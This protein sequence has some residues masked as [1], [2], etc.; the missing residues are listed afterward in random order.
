[1]KL[2]VGLV[3]AAMLLPGAVEAKK[4]KAAKIDINKQ[5]ELIDNAIRAEIAACPEKSGGVYLV[6]PYIASPDSLPPVP[7]GFEPVYISHYGRHGSRWHT[8]GDI[9]EKILKEFAK[10]KEDGNLTSTGE[11]VMG[12]VQICEDNAKG[13]TGEL[14]HL[15]E[16]QHKSIATRMAKRFPTLFETGDTIVARSSTEPR[17]I[18]SML[19]FSEALKEY[20]P[21]MVVQR[22]ASPGDQ[23]FIRYDSK[24]AQSLYDDSKPW[25]AAYIHER[26]SLFES[27]ATASKLFVNPDK[28]NN[29]PWFMSMLHNIAFTSQNIDDLNVNILPYFDNEDLYNLWKAENHGYYL[30]HGNAPESEGEGPKSSISLLQDILDRSDES[31]AGKRTQVDLRFGHDTYLERLLSLMQLGDAKAV[32]HGIDESSRVWRNYHL[33]P[34]AANLQLIVFRNAAG[35]EIAT[36]RLNERPQSVGELTE[37]APGY[38][39]WTDLRN[40]WRSQVSEK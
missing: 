23:K 33:T 39:R 35:E 6:Y 34:M 25:R 8:W 16:L 32:V 38:Y 29:L 7:A 18:I 26:D 2:A 12:L 5:N 28:L 30:C 24:G 40:F 14:T 27:K 36:V 19:A 1:M 37:Y 22:S 20:N 21:G 31:L 10:Q 13:H 15:G 3:C 17:V 9:H 11:E 4:K